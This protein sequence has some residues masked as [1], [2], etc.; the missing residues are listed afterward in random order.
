MN[1][2][3]VQFEKMNQNMQMT[4]EKENYMRVRDKSVA[5]IYYAKKMAKEREVQNYT[6][7]LYDTKTR[8]DNFAMESINITAEY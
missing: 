3:E 6:A 4:L 5:N 7:R 2:K 8:C 1:R